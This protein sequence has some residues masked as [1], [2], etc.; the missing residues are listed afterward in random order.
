MLLAVA[1]TLLLP[2]SSPSQVGYGRQAGPVVVPTGRPVIV[3][4]SSITKP[5][6]VR[7][8]AS[9][10]DEEVDEEDDVPL[11]LPPIVRR[12]YREQPVATAAPTQF[13]QWAAPDSAATSGPLRHALQALPVQQDFEVSPAIGYTI[14]FSTIADLSA[15]TADFID[16]AAADGHSLMPSADAAILL[17]L[18][19]AVVQ[20]IRSTAQPQLTPAQWSEAAQ[21]DPSNAPLV[22]E[23]RQQARRGAVRIG[24][25][26]SLEFDGA[27][28]PLY[29]HVHGD[30]HVAPFL[31]SLLRMIRPTVVVERGGGSYVTPFLLQALADNAVDF[32]REA[33][34]A[35][36]DV[37]SNY[38]LPWYFEQVTGPEGAAPNTNTNARLRQENLTPVLH[39]IHSGDE[40]PKAPEALSQLGL[41]PSLLELHRV[42]LDDVPEFA[43]DLSDSISSAVDLVWFGYED[44]GRQNTRQLYKF[45]DAYVPLL[46]KDQGYFVVQF[47]QGFFGRSFG[48]EIPWSD[49]VDE[50]R[51][52]IQVA[53]NAD[54]SVNQ[55]DLGDQEERDDTGA[56]EVQ[57]EMINL[58]EP[59]KWRAGSLSL[60][61]LSRVGVR[62]PL[63][64]VLL[65]QQIRQGFDALARQ[66][67]VEAAAHFNGGVQIAEQYQLNPAD[68]EFGQGVALSLSMKKTQ[69]PGSHPAEESTLSA[70]SGT[71]IEAFKRAIDSDPNH[72]AARNNLAMLLARAD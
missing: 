60:F 15:V 46:R 51:S 56:D 59:H 12:P 6:G 61:K 52:R 40:A 13:I 49:G 11:R 68:A 50:L 29:S 19:E 23:A 14:Q 4:A 32:V 63:G 71:A 5:S 67:P 48:E 16:Q 64:N 58:L 70:A 34:D 31:G 43:K 2:A 24:L 28:R 17:A 22:L 55:T 7:R 35:A 33:E 38:M 47:T 18:Q 62:A 65:S 27:A 37:P 57:V 44:H 9:R 41:E 53:A 36:T 25:H 10:E 66:T 20:T 39:C 3:P 26:S 45:I 21:L 8:E 30:E 69:T 1:V 54:L 42:A 72:A